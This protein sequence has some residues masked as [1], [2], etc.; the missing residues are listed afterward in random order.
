MTI[1]ICH[2]P[3]GFFENLPRLEERFHSHAADDMPWQTQSRMLSDQA[4]ILKGNIL[5]PTNRNK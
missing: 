5:Y 3:L 4:L 1:I 2:L